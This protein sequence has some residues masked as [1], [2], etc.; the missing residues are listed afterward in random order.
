MHALADLAC[1]LPSFYVLSYFVECETDD[2]SCGLKV[3]VADVQFLP[4]CK[5]PRAVRNTAA[6]ALARV[7]I[8]KSVRLLS[9]HSVS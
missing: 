3:F 7:G 2:S 1:K 5:A 6:D 8:E 4:V 9:S